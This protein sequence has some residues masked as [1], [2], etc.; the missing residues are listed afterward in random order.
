MSIQNIHFESF[1]YPSFARDS[2][3]YGTHVWSSM[4]KRAIRVRH[5]YTEENIDDVETILK[6]RF[7]GK[8][9]SDENTD[10]KKTTA[11]ARYLAATSFIFPSNLTLIIFIFLLQIHYFSNTGRALEV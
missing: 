3:Q 7:N 11:G 9:T 8:Y 1:K 2:T 5:S 4:I 10:Q 6:L